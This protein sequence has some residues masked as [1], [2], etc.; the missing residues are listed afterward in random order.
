MKKLI[1]FL[2]V[3]LG[4][5][6]LASCNSDELFE[7]ANNLAG[8]TVLTVTD[9]DAALTRGYMDEGGAQVFSKGDWIRAYDSKLQKY[10]I[11]DF[12]MTSKFTLDK[13]TNYVEEVDGKKDY[14]YAL[15]GA[16]DDNVS[17]AGW[18]D[19]KNVVL[20][21]I[22]PVVTYKQ[23]ANENADGV[24]AYKST[25]PSFGYMMP[26]G[27]G[28]W[29][30]DLHSL[31]G[32]AKITINESG[33]MD[34]AH[35]RARAM[36][37]NS[38]TKVADVTAAI[39]KWKAGSED[40]AEEVN[41]L[42]TDEGAPALS[43][44]FEAVLDENPDNWKNSQGLQR[45]D[46]DVDNGVDKAKSNSIIM[47]VL[48]NTM[49]AHTSVVYFPIVPGD[50]DAILFE[51]Y[52]ENSGICG[53]EENAH[54][55]EMSWKFVACAVKKTVERTTSLNA[56]IASAAE[57]NDVKTIGKTTTHGTGLQS[58]LDEYAALKKD[59]VIEIN[60]ATS[61]Y[62]ISNNPGTLTI[63]S[64]LEN[65]I[66]LNIYSEVSGGEAEEI[67]IVG[68]SEN[69]KLTINFIGNNTST[70]A[71]APLNITA[72]ND[73][74]ISGNLKKLTVKNEK[75]FTLAKE[76]KVFGD[77]K[78]E[79]TGD[80]ESK[81]L[82]ADNN[83]TVSLKGANI[84]ICGRLKA[85]KSLTTAGNTVVTKDAVLNKAEGGAE[86]DKWE[87]IAGTVELNA[88]YSGTL[89]LK[90]NA[91]SA[92]I[93]EDIAYIETEGKPVTVTGKVVESGTDINKLTRMVQVYYLT[94]KK[95]ISVGEGENGITL[96]SGKIGKLTGYAKTTTV[97]AKTTVTSNGTSEI[98]EVVTD[99]LLAFTA[100]WDAVTTKN[101]GTDYDKNVDG[102]VSA[103]GNIYTAAQLKHVHEVAATA[104]KNLNLQAD[105][106]I[107][108]GASWTPANI[109][110]NL[111]ADVK[112][113]GNNHTISGLNIAVPSD[114]AGFFAKVA[115]NKKLTVEKLTLEVTDINAKNTTSGG[116]TTINDKKH[117]GGLVGCLDT[118]LTLTEVKV[119]VAANSI[120]GKNISV[121]G[122]IG[123]H[124][125]GT[126][127]AANIKAPIV[128]LTG[129]LKGYG[130]VGGL[131]G[132]LGSED[133]TAKVN[134][135]ANA[136][137][138]AIVA[139]N[140]GS[141]DLTM[142]YDRHNKPATD[143]KTQWDE[144]K[145]AGTFGMLVGSVLSTE[146]EFTA[147]TT[148]KAV[149]IDG[150]A[151]SSIKDS[152]LKFNLMLGKYISETPAEYNNLTFKGSTNHEFGC[153]KAIA[154]SD[155]KTGE[156]KI[157]INDNKYWGDSMVERFC[158]NQLNVE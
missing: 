35:V 99:D 156:S 121:G 24:V 96:N 111:T 62:S 123:A 64:T 1:K 70:N 28:D 125:A 66:T 114:D 146:A 20:M 76:T 122:L 136:A 10:D 74:E 144:Y 78:V 13:T 116:T 30:V 44:W 130:Y 22:N 149:T 77:V 14:K 131:I 129:A 38:T 23:Q 155:N 26:D 92:A 12:A 59:V 104:A 113:A 58:V 19:G 81:Y 98:D 39:A 153:S 158:I 21:K 141:F 142:G 67:K 9:G 117:I 45:V 34:I 15:F 102:S 29:K 105:I 97:T 106:T 127:T 36:K 11:F 7:N 17:Y 42:L 80:I 108:T 87:H 84:K 65:D 85:G 88:V 154:F 63:P 110:S 145:Y 140:G 40:Y 83:A 82:A 79:T 54:A 118:D 3:C 71:L 31:T 72:D 124:E 16:D 37:F 148:A 94:V 115:G 8:K 51:Y 41:S 2:P 46:A 150:T 133:G 6:A 55:N 101:N 132:S 52:E 27:D 73:I 126:L 43:G 100:T 32:R 119:S 33:S 61:Y 112:F 128:T 147:G 48:K 53:D 103:T 4:A 107:G 152:K 137:N 90:E 25:V 75:N 151:I 93:N 57:V 109:Y 50:Y 138:T 18:K 120:Q 157:A 95:P 47:N 143:A 86:F 60:K 135:T 139:V 89:Y 5:L 49:D 69:G 68:G 91:E 134:I 56:T